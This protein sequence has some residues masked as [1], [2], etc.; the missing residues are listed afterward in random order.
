MDAQPELVGVPEPSAAHPGRCRVPTRFGAER[1]CR[2]VARG[3]VPEWTA[4]LDRAQR[5]GSC[6]ECADV[7]GLELE[8]FRGT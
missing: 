6:Q 3:T 5:L 2:R 7:F 1:P 8:P 4:P